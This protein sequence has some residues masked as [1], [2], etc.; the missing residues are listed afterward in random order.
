MNDMTDAEFLRSWCCKGTEEESARLNAIADLL[1]QW[2]DEPP[3][4]EGDWIQKRDGN[5]RL[6]AVSAHR[7]A[8]FAR[9]HH[10]GDRWFKLPE[11]QE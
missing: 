1:G 4:S 11:M 6:A 5:H 10:P 3:D 8:V 7:L 2:R 9:E